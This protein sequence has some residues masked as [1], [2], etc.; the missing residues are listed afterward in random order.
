MDGLYLGLRIAKEAE[1]AGERP[2]QRIAKEIAWRDPRKYCPNMT[3]K[4]LDAATVKI[5]EMTIDTLTCAF[6][7]AVRDEF[8]FGAKRSQRLMDRIMIKVEDLADGIITWDDYVKQLNIE[9]GFD[10]KIRRNE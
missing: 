2:A 3:A 8:D 10:L 6:I 1:E 7:A 4:E 5:K 9:L